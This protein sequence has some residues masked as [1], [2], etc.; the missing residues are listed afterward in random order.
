MRTD[1]SGG[2]DLLTSLDELQYKEK[3][4]N[5]NENGNDELNDDLND[6]NASQVSKMSKIGHGSHMNGNAASKMQFGKN[7]K[8][9][10][11]GAGANTANRSGKT[12]PEPWRNIKSRKQMIKLVL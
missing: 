12:H 11:A 2:I 7:K 10:G 6:G 3:I 1:V 4:L 8:G 9:P 5:Y